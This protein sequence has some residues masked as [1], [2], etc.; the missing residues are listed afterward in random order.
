MHRDG[1]GGGLAHLRPGGAIMSDLKAIAVMIW[2]YVIEMW[3]DF[4]L[5]ECYALE[6]FVDG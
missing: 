3:R 4:K 2:K 1:G 5:I 6:G